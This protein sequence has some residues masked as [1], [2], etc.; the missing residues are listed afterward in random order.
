MEELGLEILEQSLVEL[1]NKVQDIDYHDI[2]IGDFVNIKDLKEKGLFALAHVELDGN[3]RT[4][5]GLISEKTTS[6]INIELKATADNLPVVDW[7]KSV[8][9]SKIELER[10]SRMNLKLDTLKVEHLLQNA[11]ATMQTNGFIGHYADNRLKGLLTLDITPEITELDTTKPNAFIL[12]LV[13]SFYKKTGGTFYPNVIA[14]DSEDLMDMSATV[15]DVKEGVSITALTVAKDLI[16]QLAGHPVEIKAI[17]KQYAQFDSN[18][19][20]L[21]RGK[22]RAGTLAK[23]RA[24]AYINDSSY[25]NYNVAYMPERLEVEPF[26]LMAFQTGYRMGISSVAL[27]YK[28]AMVYVDYTVKPSV[29]KNE[30]DKTNEGGKK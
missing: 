20:S 30:G 3:G 21:A 8:T 13:K 7:A 5:D 11:L 17:P 22:E 9:F 25:I 4:D 26:N 10:A 28:E 29:H 14:I 6:L 12:G 23:K 16:Q 18:G 15:I 2:V 27:K 1:D 24:M 19:I